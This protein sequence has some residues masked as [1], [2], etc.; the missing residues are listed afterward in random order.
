MN[1]EKIPRWLDKKPFPA[2]PWSSRN[3]FFSAQ[4]DR[5]LIEL[6]DFLTRTKPLQAAFIVKR[7][8]DALPLILKHGSEGSRE[9]IRLQLERLISTP[10][11]VYVLAD[12]VNF[13]GLGI[14]PSEKYQGKG[15]GLLQVLE[16]MKD[17]NEALDTVGEFAR[18]ANTVLENRINNSPLSRNEQRWLP[19]WQKR[20]N[21]YLKQ[22]EVTCLQ[23]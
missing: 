11:G 18:S 6:K 20:V 15:W 7:L 17:E 9:K 22:E 1:G 3:N 23:E 4:N 13:K 5:R 16:G 14:A 12:Y 10:S 8:E 2:C 21:S 19:G